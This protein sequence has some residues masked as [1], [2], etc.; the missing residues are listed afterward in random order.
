[1]NDKPWWQSKTIWINV[2]TGAGAVA[3]AVSNANG[4]DGQPII[5]AKAVSI[6][7]LLSNVANVVLRLVTTSTLSNGDS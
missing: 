2:L 1:M 6:V 4:P 5:G 7:L 3:L